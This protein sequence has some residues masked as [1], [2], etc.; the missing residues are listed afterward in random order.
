MYKPTNLERNP[1]SLEEA[2]VRSLKSL[3]DTIGANLVSKAAHIR[4]IQEEIKQ[5][6]GKLERDLP[7]I[8]SVVTSGHLDVIIADIQKA[9]PAKDG[10]SLE[11]KTKA[12]HGCGDVFAAAAKGEVFTYSDFDLSKAYYEVEFTYDSKGKSFDNAS[13]LE[14][15]SGLDVGRNKQGINRLT[16]RVTADGR[17]QAFDYGE[18]TP[19]PA[20]SALNNKTS[21]AEF[22][23]VAALMPTIN[24]W[25]KRASGQAA[26]AS[27][28]PA[29]S[30]STRS[31]WFGR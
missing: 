18:L 19:D 21:S 12:I 3:S 24:A 29:P 14:A 7:K 13:M 27:S 2:G 9:L 1:I 8:A 30:T 16:L 25:V 5:A 6:I 26:P 28:M 23:T 22:D 31:L 17:L 10:K 4:L 20:M 11:I 15:V